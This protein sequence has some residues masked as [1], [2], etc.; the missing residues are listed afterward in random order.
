[1]AITE[2]ER[3]LRAKAS[4]LRYRRTN[5]GRLNRLK[6]MAAYRLRDVAA[7]N[8]KA[9]AHIH[10][11]KDDVFRAYGGWVCACCKE[12]EK[13]FLTFGHMLNNGAAERRNLPGRGRNGNIALWRR[14][15]REGY[16]PGYRIECY[17]CNCGS[18]R[19]GGICPHERIA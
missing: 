2:Q 4:S 11:L 12:T 10:K 7:Y 16:P 14:L 5:K 3:L 18:F 15:R 13:S 9:A 8:A 6:N 19:N 1:M 17:N